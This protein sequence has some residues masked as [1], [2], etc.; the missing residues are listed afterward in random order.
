M[1]NHGIE[2]TIIYCRMESEAKGEMYNECKNLG[3]MRNEDFADY[4]YDR[5]WWAQK[6][7]EL[8]KQLDDERESLRS[9]GAAP[10]GD[11][12]S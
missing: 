2:H 6:A 1:K 5:D 9:A 4:A 10:K 11:R 7:T 12:I 8:K 3:T